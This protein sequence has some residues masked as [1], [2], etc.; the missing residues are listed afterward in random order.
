MK[1][2]A[3]LIGRWPSITDF[4]ADIGV[5]A[6]TARQM[7]HRDSID[8]VYWQAMVEGAARR[9]IAGVTLETL[10]MIAAEKRAAAPRDPLQQEAAHG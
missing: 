6:G 1:R 10:A 3:D 9:D 8:G 7:K 5:A 4:A 2:F